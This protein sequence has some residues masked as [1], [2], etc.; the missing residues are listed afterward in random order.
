MTLQELAKHYQETGEYLPEAEALEEIHLMSLAERI[1]KKYDDYIEYC[2]FINHLPEE[3][4]D[5]MI[6]LEV[7][8][9]QA[10]NGFIKP[11][12]WECEECGVEVECNEF[13]VECGRLFCS[14]CMTDNVCKECKE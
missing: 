8:Y 12:K 4:L 2:N 13:C 7:G 1:Q 10:D 6:E 3:T 9:W 11:W 5:L 14:K